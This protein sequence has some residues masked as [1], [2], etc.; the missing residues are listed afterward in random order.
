MA[1]LLFLTFYSLIPVAGRS[2]AGPRPKAWPAAAIVRSRVCV[3]IVLYV[4]GPAD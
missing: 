2:Q 1:D 4:L 3:R